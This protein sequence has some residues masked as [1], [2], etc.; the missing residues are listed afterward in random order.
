MRQEE[1]E[2]IYSPTRRGYSR[3]KL[4]GGCPFC[5]PEV[6]QRESLLQTLHTNVLAN[7]KPSVD[8]HILVIPSRHVVTPRELTHEEALDLHTA[9]EEA[10]EKLGQLFDTTHFTVG[11]NQGEFAGGSVDHLHV[12]VVP[13]RRRFDSGLE[14]IGNLHVL[15]VN[16]NDLISMFREKFPLNGKGEL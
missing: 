12:H 8:G 9:T 11:Y 4:N 5:N 15:T 14:L 2:Y 6:I 16:C 10:K 1:H 3:E 7:F 13:R